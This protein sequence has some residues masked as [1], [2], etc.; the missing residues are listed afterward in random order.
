MLYLIVLSE[1]NRRVHK[2]VAA[3]SGGQFHNHRDQPNPYVVQQESFFSD[4]QKHVHVNVIRDKAI[5]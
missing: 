5:K 4:V 1:S 2:L 3:P